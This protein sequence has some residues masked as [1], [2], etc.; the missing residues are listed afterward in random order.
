VRIRLQRSILVAAVLAATA[1]L[2]A[3]GGEAQSQVVATST[4]PRGTPVEVA[5]VERGDLAPVYLATAALEA[6]REATLLAEMAGEV[7]SIEVEEGD[8]VV[9]GQVLARVD[10]TRQALELKQVASVADRLASDVARNEALVERRMISREA[11]DRARYESDTQVAAVELK[12][13]D[14]GK[15]A[16]RAPFAGV[17][18]RRFIKDGQ[19]LKREDQA[20]AIA[21]FS[22]LQARIDVP[23]RSVALIRPGVPVS[24]EADAIP[25]RAFGARIERIAPVVDQASGTV[26]AVVQIDNAD[27]ALRPGLFVRLGVNYERIADALLVPRAALVEDD[28]RR[29]V[30]LVADGKAIKRE[31]RLGLADGERV[32]VLEGLDAGDQVVVVGQNTLVDGTPVRALAPGAADPAGTATAAL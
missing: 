8:R 14:L 22:S 28:G 29:H 4:A 26:G 10:H 21:D 24:F 2:G 3:C 5:A 12:R 13:L 9:A 11:Y 6:E 17:V 16:I 27:S 7:V 23:E 18:T 25:G 20:F 1:G 32:Q 19:W 30:F 15:T 31:V